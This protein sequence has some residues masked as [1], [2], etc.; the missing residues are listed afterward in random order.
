MIPI[1]GTSLYIYAVTKEHS[2]KLFVVY[3]LLSV[4]WSFELRYFS[5]NKSNYCG[6]FPSHIADLFAAKYLLVGCVVSP[7]I[8]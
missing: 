3:L 7:Y 2:R 1:P 8:F 4:K 5:T 6:T